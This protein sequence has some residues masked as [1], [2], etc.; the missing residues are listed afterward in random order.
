MRADVAA[1]LLALS[2]RGRGMNDDLYPTML[3]PG[4]PGGGDSADFREFTPVLR[5]GRNAVMAARR[6]A[7][8][9]GWRVH[10]CR[11]ALHLTD[12]TG[13]IERLRAEG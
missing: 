11:D 2:A 1:T 13:L 4:G 6:A 3:R 12:E 10:R 8:R 9:V 7:H 5:V